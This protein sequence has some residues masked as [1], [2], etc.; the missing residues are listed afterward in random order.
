MSRQTC[1]QCE[2]FHA[3]N[4]PSHGECYRYPPTPYKDGTVDAPRI[5]ANRTSCGEFKPLPN[6]ET[7]QPV[8]KAH[9]PSHGQVVQPDKKK[10]VKPLPQIPKPAQSGDHRDTTPAA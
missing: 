2:H 4:P 8:T 10:P 1:I 6:G 7:A 9:V 3:F 5:K